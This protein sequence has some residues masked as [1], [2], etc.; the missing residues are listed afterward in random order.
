MKRCIK[1]DKQQEV[2]EESGWKEEERVV[3][4]YLN[5]ERV[6]GVGDKDSVG[7]K[8]EALRAYLEKEIG[9][10]FYS[11]YNLIKD[12]KDEDYEGAKSMLGRDKVKYIPLVVQLIVCE[13][14]YY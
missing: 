10:E 3:P 2:D 6:P 8:I 11:I 1:G 7:S 14:N 13:D 12:E 4:K 9:D 5:L